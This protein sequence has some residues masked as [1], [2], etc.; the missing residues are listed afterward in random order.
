MAMAEAIDHCKI[1]ESCAALMPGEPDPSDMLANDIRECVAEIK[2]LQKEDTA[3]D[4]VIEAAK[5]IARHDQQHGIIP[6]ERWL[7]ELWDLV[8]VQNDAV[9]DLLR[10]QSDAAGPFQCG[11]RA[12]P[13]PLAIGR[14]E[15]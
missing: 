2:R 4:A 10:L 9:S 7:R 11:N 3:R 15:G 13:N 6:E 8:D 12:I 5:E 1:V 14:L